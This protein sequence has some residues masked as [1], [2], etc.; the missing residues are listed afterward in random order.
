MLQCL[1][2]GLRLTTVDEADEITAL[3]EERTG[4]IPH[5]DLDVLGYRDWLAG[6]QRGIA[7]HHAGMLPTFKEVVEE[8]FAAG[9][10]RAVF[11]T[12]TLALGINMP[13]RTVVIERLDKWNGETHADL[14]PG[15]YTQLTGRA[16]RRGIDV[17]GHAVVLWQPGL[18][19]VAV[20]GLAGTRTYPLSSSFRPS[21]NMAVNLV[22]WAGRQRA[23]ALLESSF[24]QFQ[25]DRA[26]VGIARQA[27]RARQAID[28]ATARCELGDF[29]E[30]VALRRQLSQLEADQSRQRAAARRADALRSLEQLRRGDIIRVP[31][32]RRAGVAVVL[33]HGMNGNDLPLPLVLTASHHVKRL[34]V[35]DFPVPV[36]PIDRIRI[37]SWFSVR[38]AKHRRDLAATMR[39]KLA[40]R[41]LGK[42]PRG[43]GTAAEDEE[44]ASLRRRLRR[45]PCHGCP[46]REQHA[47]Q[48][49]KQL[50]LE[51]EAEA[52]DAPGRGA[53]ACHRP[54]LRPRLR[55]A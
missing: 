11:A 21:Y 28:E 43:G 24:A 35:T 33:D 32:G 54:D 6:L 4:D 52:L 14:T 22:G 18:D 49:E 38:S 5:D 7:A 10:V 9:L 50:R 8:L 39:N 25:A 13:A 15:E 34:S 27:R 53:V 40:G 12:E 16:G 30:Y 45:H 48:A 20:A 37:P 1:T 19:P 26:V 44:I 23:A 42:L 31:S 29:A 55:A 41:D 47:R 51:R 36:T 3:V 17:E 46:D 2:A